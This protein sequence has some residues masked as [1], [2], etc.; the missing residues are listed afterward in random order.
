MKRIIQ[1]PFHPLLFALYP[2]LALYAVNIQEVS[3]SVV[4]RP[5]LLSLAGS[6]L[7]LVALYLILRNWHKAALLSTVILL[8]FFSYGRIYDAFKA[9]PLVDMNIVRHRYLMGIFLLLLA[10][11]GWFIIKTIRDIKPLSGVLNIITSLLV[12]ITG[13]QITG[14]LV[15]TSGG[16]AAAGKLSTAAGSISLSLPKSTPDVYYIVLDSYTRSD[17]LESELN[18]DNTA[19]LNELEQMGFYVAGCSRTNYNKTQSSMAS[20][21]NMSYLPELYVEAAKQGISEEDIWMLI[22]PSKVRHNFESIGYQIVAFDTGYKWTSITD[23]DIY[24]SRGQNAFGMQYVTPFE[25]MLIDS[26][27]LSIYSDFNRKASWNAYADSIHPKANY[28]GLQEY[29]LDQLPQV[30]ALDGPTFTYAH[31]N[32][33]HEP[34]VFSPDGYL[35]DSKEISF[36]AGYIHALDY[37]DARLIPILQ[38][39]LDRSSTPPII[40]IQGD[41]GYWVDDGTPSGENI[42]PVLNAYY[43]PGLGQD[44]LYSTI[45][46]VNTFRLIFNDYFGGQYELLPDISYH[47]HDLSIP[48]PEG[49][50]E[51]R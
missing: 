22:K 23:A 39:I 37:M 25:Q 16:E 10:W 36:P 6:V 8:A 26:T 44:G 3:W 48:V 32:I 30:A 17:V 15:R 49:F 35:I 5:L 42:S 51:C 4:W 31:I 46:P 40:I 12:L 7:V 29:I 18:Y 28:I 13:I 19:F 9:T 33:T 1:Y 43:L 50:T 14:Y 27:M 11:A 2:T 47:I 41:H 20:S 38:E 45:S 34:Y 24:L 21:L